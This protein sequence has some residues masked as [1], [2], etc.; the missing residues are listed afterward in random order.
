M[1]KVILFLAEGFEEVEAVTVIDYLRRM[2]IEVITTSIS[3]EKLVVGA[4]NITIA[5]DKILD[6]IED[7]EDYNGLIIPG[8][9]PGATNL[10]DEGRVIDLVKEANKEGKLLAAIC[11]G[12][13]VLEKAG[14]IQDK[15][16][17]TYP[18]FEEVIVDGKGIYK[19]KAVVR[20]KNIITSRGPSLAVDFALEIVDYLLGRD[21]VDRLKEDILYDY[22]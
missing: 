19:E 22:K 1:K 5:A 21:Q 10:R 8:G 12:P 6:Q 17:T 18:G 16:I 4:H 11:A 13:I 7:L 14:I 2:D 20:D 15:K 3:K 9:L